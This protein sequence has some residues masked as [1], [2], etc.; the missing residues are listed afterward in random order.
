MCVAC[1]ITRSPH[2]QLYSARTVQCTHT[3]MR[4][5]Y[6]PIGST[7]CFITGYS[8]TVDDVEYILHIIKTGFNQNKHCPFPLLKR[9]DPKTI[10]Q[11]Y[12]PSKRKHN[13]KT[14]R[15]RRPEYSRKANHNTELTKC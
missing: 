2:M 10:T 3:W 7:T 12:R 13:I 14:H 4:I 5:L 15:K 6:R 9:R 11:N 1:T 8:S